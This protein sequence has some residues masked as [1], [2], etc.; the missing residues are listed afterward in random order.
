MH[1]AAAGMTDVLNFTVGEPDFVTP[2]PIIGERFN[3]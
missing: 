2:R 1:T 3:L